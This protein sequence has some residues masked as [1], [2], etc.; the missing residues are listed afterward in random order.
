MRKA[1]TWL[2][3]FIDILIFAVVYNFSAMLARL[4]STSIIIDTGKYL[5]NA[6]I[7]ISTLLLARFCARVYT[8]VWRYANSRAYLQ[9]V[10]AD[11][12]GGI[13]ATIISW[14][15]HAT[16]IG[17]WQNASI[18]AMFNVVTLS[19]RFIYQQYYRHL[20]V[21][22]NELNKIGVA[23]VGAG[24]V[25]SL[26][27]QE[28]MYNSSSHYRP[29]F[30]ID[31]HP[32]KIGNRVCGLKVYAEDD[33]IIELLRTMPV[34][35]VF[36]ALPSIDTETA[37]RLFNFYS[38][39]GCKVKLYD[40]S[41]REG[42][43]DEKSQ[44]RNI[45]EVR[46]ED[47]LFRDSLTINNTEALEYYK[48][49]TV[50]ITGGGGSIGSELC[51]QIARHNPKQIVIFDIYENNAYDI[52]QELT[53]KYGEKLNLAVE[54]GSV[55]DR[56][57]LEAIFA[58]YRPEVVFHAAA[59]KHVP[60]MEHS[61]CEAVKNNVLGTNNTADMAEKY[62]VKKFILIST[63]KAVNPTN[64]MGASKRLC[65]MLIQCRKDSKTS[66]A[67]VRFGNVLSSNGSVIP[68]FKRQIENG[69]P[70][71][72]TD[73]RIIRYFMTIP[74]ASQLVMQAGSMARSGELFVL[75]MG[76]P[77]K[78]LDLAENLI[79]LSGLK[80]YKDIDIVEIG[81]RPGEKLYE[82]LLIKTEDMCKTDNNM[83]FIENDEP[84]TRLEIAKKLAVL[85]KALDD[86][87]YE[88]SS[89]IVKQAM[90]AIVPT[91]LDPDEVNGRAAEAA[92]MKLADNMPRTM[93]VVA[94]AKDEQ[95]IA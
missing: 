59:H 95:I 65:E 38:M 81:L 53:L 52:Q 71:T 84:L 17:I 72:I 94:A 2:L 62:E 28:L 45:R 73:K 88:I 19:T 67:A 5:M 74:E 27:A 47:L 90:K 14:Y 7:F 15:I 21:S 4:T 40:M 26:L 37:G 60:L 83:I 61:S 6:G 29:I 20:N 54:I 46:I 23:I 79:H 25:G 35:E 63:D 58:H 68:L 93:E 9:M 31:K 12:F 8:N 42:I 77:V 49:K 18:V 87:E 44:K 3:M 22:M 86:S 57:R 32:S 66:F 43:S 64:I 70:V 16:Y 10:I 30:F 91:Y 55:R 48:N 41:F 13:A 89:N 51:R 39:S 24:Q 34:Q 92:E 36:I 69:G 56:V 80:P 78:I 33:N 85:I 75:D 11:V 82:E 1:R 76:K 50:L